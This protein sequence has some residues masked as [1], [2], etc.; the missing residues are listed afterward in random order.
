MKKLLIILSAALFVLASCQKEVDFPDAGGGGTGGGTGNLLVK[1]VS[2]TGSDSIVTVYTYNASNKLIRMKLT[3]MSGGFDMGNDFK[4]YRNA[5]GVI[6]HYVQIN[7]N[8]VLLGIDS[9]TTVLHYD[10]ASSKYTS[11]VT[12]MSL[13]GFAVLDSMVFVYDANKRVIEQQSWQAIPALGSP[14]E[15][16]LKTK[17]T[18]AANGN[19]SELNQ[20]DPSSGTDDLI[21]TIKYTYDN[22]TSSINPTLIFLNLGEAGAINH[23]DW[24]SV[25]N[26]NKVEIIDVNTPANNRTSNVTYTYNAAGK[27]VSGTNTTTPGGAVDNL[28]YFYQ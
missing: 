19:V 6:T 2:K 8:F 27:P 22:K 14:Y 11:A 3:G 26:A 28:T 15:L 16:T 7:P 5:S 10:A 21:S 13:L 18:I 25:N 20:Y 9:V 17:F 1:S 4:Y 23:G 12:E 24:I